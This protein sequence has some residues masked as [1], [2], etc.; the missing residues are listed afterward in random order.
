M[1]RSMM[2]IWVV[3]LVAAGLGAT[4]RAE[5][6]IND[7]PT[8]TAPS[9]DGTGEINLE[10]LKGKIVIVHFWASASEPTIKAAEK[11]LELK[12]TWG[13]RGLEII[14]ISGDETAEKMNET[15]K[16]KGFAWP[17][18]LD[19]G[20]S[21]SGQ[22]GVKQ[23]DPPVAF[24][25]NA[26]GVLV[27][28]GRPELI[29]PQ[30]ERAFKTT[31][32]V[33]VDAKQVELALASLDKMEAAIKDNKQE[34]AMRL[35]GSIPVAAKADGR[36]AARLSAV[37]KQLTEYGDRAVTEA[38][39]LI[40]DK[41]FAEA[42]TKLSAVARGLPNTPAATN[43]KKALAKMLAMPG[44]RTAFESV[45]REQTAEDELEVAK[46]LAAENKREQAYAKYKQ[47]AST[48]AGTPSADEAKL[49]MQEF[50]KDPEF[51]KKVTQSA[52]QN[53]AQAL[54]TMAEKYREAGRNDLA[55]DKYTDVAKLYPGTPYAA[56]AEAALKELDSGPKKQ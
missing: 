40:K 27:W 28:R 41:K 34:D 49:A 38:D 13:L 48:Y 30:L 26:K 19:G 47:V 1:I 22:W 44:A 17:Q 50:E 15:A 35:L 2:R 39:S 54:I 6:K 24:L 10:H 46:R 29:E 20:S 18:A 53:R 36:V 43:A 12:K 25:I 21:I 16:G 11:L 5:F 51:L 31:P 3:A 8:L 42:G 56:K 45:Q 7:K 32:P 55:R 9:A 37:E 14:G 23:D 52:A 4:A 33:V